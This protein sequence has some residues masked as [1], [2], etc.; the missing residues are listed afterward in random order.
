MDTTRGGWC[1]LASHVLHEP[2]RDAVERRSTETP[3]GAWP[4]PPPVTACLLWRMP[5]RSGSC[6]SR[7]SPRLSRQT[8]V[9]PPLDPSIP[10]IP[11]WV[12]PWPWRALC[13]SSDQAEWTEQPHVKISEASAGHVPGLTCGG[14]STPASPCASSLLCCFSGCSGPPQRPRLHPATA[15]RLSAKRPSPT[16][17]TSPHPRDNSWRGTST[18]EEAAVPLKDATRRNMVVER[19]LCA[20][21]NSRES[22]RGDVLYSTCSSAA[23]THGASPPITQP[24]RTAV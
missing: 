6:C 18:T 5:C 15:K 16:A 9:S 4:A 11:G 23:V 7:R 13:G 19:G 20:T 2:D 8:L 17:A 10:V 12:S 24:T 3:P 14:S 1:G 21:V 22:K